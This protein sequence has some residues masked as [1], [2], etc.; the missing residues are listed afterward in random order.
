[1]LTNSYINY[2]IVMN[3]IDRKISKL[4]REIE[5]EYTRLK[6]N[7]IVDEIHQKYLERIGHKH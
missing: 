7:K 4:E 1:M 5:E 3:H 2:C 6:G